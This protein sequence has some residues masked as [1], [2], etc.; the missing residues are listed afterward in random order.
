LLIFG[1]LRHQGGRIAE[2]NRCRSPVRDR[3]DGRDPWRGHLD[4]TRAG[5][6]LA[7]HP[8]AT[9]PHDLVDQRRGAPHRGLVGIGGT[10]NH[11]EHGP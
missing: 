6:H 2:D 9:I 7:G 1:V 10:R 8:A 11:G 4:H 3:H 5:Q